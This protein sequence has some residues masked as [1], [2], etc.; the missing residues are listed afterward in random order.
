MNGEFVN[1]IL[2]NRHWAAE[3]HCGSEWLKQPRET[4]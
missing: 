2:A 4:V 1:D 3:L